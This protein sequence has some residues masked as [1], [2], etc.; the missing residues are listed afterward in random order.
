MTGPVRSLYEDYRGLVEDLKDRSPSGLA[1]L[2]RTYHKVILVA[3]ASSL[4]NQVKRVIE[5]MFREHGRDELSFFVADRVMSRGYHQLFDW[6]NEKAKILFSSFGP[7]CAKLFEQTLK[8]DNEFNKEHFAFMRLGKLRNM[9][10]HRDYATYALD[11]T[12][13]EL[14]ELYRLAVLFP[15]RFEGIIF[16]STPDTK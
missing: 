13:D 8:N 14:Y 2:N 9:L 15:G 4:E 3:A 1:A 11:E 6:N 7:G 10:V 12:P 16:T 5:S